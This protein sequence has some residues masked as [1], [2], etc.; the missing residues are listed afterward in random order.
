MKIRLLGSA[1]LVAAWQAALEKDYEIKGAR[2]PARGSNDLR[3]YFDIDDR[4]AAEIVGMSTH[5]KTASD[6]SKK[7][8]CK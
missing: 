6:Q 1:D 8:I 4:K 5:T 7:K 3:V 2:Y